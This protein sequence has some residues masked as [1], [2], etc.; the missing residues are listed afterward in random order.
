MIEARQEDDPLKLIQI[1]R[2]HSDRNVANINCS[3]LYRHAYTH[4]KALI[5]Q[6]QQELA[7]DFAFIIKADIPQNKK[8]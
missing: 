8:L 3:Y 4:S 7:R 6:Y 2:S 1:I 5:E